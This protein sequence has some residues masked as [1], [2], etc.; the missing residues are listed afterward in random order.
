MNL[1]D[2]KYK[3]KVDWW[4]HLTFGLLVIL[5]IWMIVIAPFSLGVDAI[6]VLIIGGLILTPCNILTVPMWLNTYYLFGKEGLK[7]RSG[8]FAKELIEY[9]RI[10]SICETRNPL[11][12]S[13]AISLDRMEIT[14]RYKRGNFTDTVVVSPKDKESFTQELL[15]RNENVEVLDK[16]P[17]TRGMKMLLVVTAILSVIALAATAVMTIVG[18]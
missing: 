4:I 13:T 8:F 7:V 9:D 15:K 12:T 14:Y 5:N 16:K 1:P 10:I 6:P 2:V 11:S 17:L 18:N 3:S